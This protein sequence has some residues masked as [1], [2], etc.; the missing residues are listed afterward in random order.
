MAAAFHAGS[1]FAVVAEA[2]DASSA[3][4]EAARVEPDL[5]LLHTRLPPGNWGEVCSTLKAA[6]P[7]PNV[8]VR[9]HE[10]DQTTLLEAIEAGADGYVSG[11]MRLAPLVDAV[12]QVL[13]GHMY[14]PPRMLRPLIG[15]LMI[16]NLER[17][18]VLR[19]FLTLT[20]RER[21]VLSLLVEGRGPGA[22]AA[23]LY[24]SP[25]TARTHVQNIIEK[26]GVHSRVQVVTLAVTHEALAWL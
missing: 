7:T 8:V 13:D 24:I 21:E 11:E 5:V 17:S 10:P 19:A 14:V 18:A 1:G 26:L 15:D 25:Q 22:I 9:Q 4:A 23:L 12:R 2:E 16:R 3:V 6:A 20:P